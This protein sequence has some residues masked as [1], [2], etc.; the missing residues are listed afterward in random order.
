MTGS[1]SFLMYSSLTE[2][3]GVSLASADDTA[4]ALPPISKIKSA[5]A[6]DFDA[7]KSDSFVQW[8][9]LVSSSAVSVFGRV[10]CNYTKKTILMT[11]CQSVMYRSVTWKCNV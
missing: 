2:I 1:T 5:F 7:S 4:S 9:G 3:R 8:C 6:I 11:V 10:V